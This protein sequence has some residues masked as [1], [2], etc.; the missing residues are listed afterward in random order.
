MK[1]INNESHMRA[2][3]DGCAV[4]LAVFAIAKITNAVLFVKHRRGNRPRPALCEGRIAALACSS[5]LV[6][7]GA[8][9]SDCVC[10]V[11]V[12]CLKPNLL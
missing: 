10:E 12:M 5:V 3:A 9:T 6:L 4:R 2:E 1:I 7:G 8:I 11:S